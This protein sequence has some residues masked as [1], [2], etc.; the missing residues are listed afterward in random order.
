MSTSLKKV[1]L[2]RL[3]KPRCLLV[4]HY[5]ANRISIP[6][7]ARTG[8]LTEYLWHQLC[9]FEAQVLQKQDPSAHNHNIN[10]IVCFR[11]H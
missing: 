6:L 4:V 1:N 11:S 10:N 8:N 9:K 7:F 3:Q 5:R 2:E